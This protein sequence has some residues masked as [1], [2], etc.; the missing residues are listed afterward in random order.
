VLTLSLESRHHEQSTFLHA[1]RSEY[2]SH[3]WTDHV[4]TQITRSWRNTNST[5][6]RTWCLSTAPARIRTIA[7]VKTLL[8][9][10]LMQPVTDAWHTEHVPNTDTY[11]INEPCSYLN[12]SHAILTS[13]WLPLCSTMRRNRYMSSRLLNFE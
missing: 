9:V 2:W 1:E 10:S 11:N 7:H 12:A 6:W 4:A 8:K 3:K 13:K 5:P